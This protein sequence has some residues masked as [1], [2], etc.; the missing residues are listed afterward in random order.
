MY[1]KQ[2]E[3]EMFDDY[4]ALIFHL[5]EH[6][7]KLIPVETSAFCRFSFHYTPLYLNSWIWIISVGKLIIKST[8]IRLAQLRGERLFHGGTYTDPAA[9]WHSWIINGRQARPC[10]LRGT[11]SCIFDETQIEGDGR[12]IVALFRGNAT[13]TGC[14]RQ[15]I[16]VRP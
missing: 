6:F 14:Y 12:I 16:F 4:Y 8:Q 13:T 10:L 11:I 3:I 5:F 1:L 9:R 7:W 15:S 2:K